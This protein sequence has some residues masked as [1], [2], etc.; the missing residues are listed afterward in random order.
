MTTD[1]STRSAAV[2]M[3]RS[4]EA[5][6]SEVAELAGV[7]RQGARWWARQEGINASA[8][9]AARLARIWATLRSRAEQP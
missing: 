8:A 3:L 6:L 1:T 4:G 5:T 7:T 9:R 2:T